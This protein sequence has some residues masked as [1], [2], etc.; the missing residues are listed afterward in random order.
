MVG[1][2]PKSKAGRIL[3]QCSGEHK[4]CREGSGWRLQ[5]ESSARS[6]EGFTNG[7]G[8]GGGHHGDVEVQCHW[9]KVCGKS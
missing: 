8:C 5:G 7:K 4:G 3:L 2:S 1:A 6:C 9:V